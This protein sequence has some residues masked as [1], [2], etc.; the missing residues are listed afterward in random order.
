MASSDP[1]LGRKQENQKRKRWLGEAEPKRIG[2]VL[3]YSPPRKLPKMI[4]L[5]W[6]GVGPKRKTWIFWR[7]TKIAKGHVAE[8][9]I[10][11]LMEAAV[12]G[13]RQTGERRSLLYILRYTLTEIAEGK[14]Q[15]GRHDSEHQIDKGCR[16]QLE[17]YHST[18]N[19]WSPW[20]LPVRDTSLPACGMRCE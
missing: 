6:A 3:A 19:V 7:G 17:R 1:S 10:A 15:A 20:L 9:Q 14:D 13:D 8:R 16:R 5:N 18:A 12:A 11:P 2:S 4:H